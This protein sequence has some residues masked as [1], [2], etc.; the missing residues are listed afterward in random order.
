MSD[1]DGQRRLGDLKVEGL[2]Y[3]LPDLFRRRKF[4]TMIQQKNPSLGKCLE[5]NSNLKGA[6]REITP[7]PF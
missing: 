3:Y 7:A 1:A 6:G 4:R 2:R 5:P